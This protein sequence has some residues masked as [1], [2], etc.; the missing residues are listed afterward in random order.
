MRRHRRVQIGDRILKG[1]LQ[2]STKARLSG[3]K[4]TGKGRPQKPGACAAAQLTNTHMLASDKARAEILASIER[5]L[6][7]TNFGG[8]Q[9]GTTSSQF[10]VPAREA[11]RVENGLAL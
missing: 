9:A 11:C 7:A 2:D 4:P 3:V 8:G 10:V 5:G 6:C 1:G